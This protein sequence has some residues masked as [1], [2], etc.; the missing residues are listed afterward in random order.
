MARVKVP[1]KGVQ[2]KNWDDVDS[3]LSEIGQLSQKIAAEEAAYNVEEAKQRAKL[4]DKHAPLRARIEELEIG[5]QAFCNDN[6]SDFGDKKS[7]DLQHGRVGFR[8]GMPKLEKV[9]KTTWEGILEIVKRSQHK[10]A[11]IRT[12]EELAKDEILL[13]AA[14]WNDTNG[15]EGLS[16]QALNDLGVAVTQEETFGYE[17]KLAIEN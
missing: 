5:M 16:P 13:Q 3:A 15:K 1:K 9:I 10:A 8:L 6:R 2:M 4:S 11:L 12:K 17:P 14:L 7:K